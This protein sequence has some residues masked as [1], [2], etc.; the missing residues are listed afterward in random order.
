MQ[1]YH[2]HCTGIKRLFIF[3]QFSIRA[4]TLL[5]LLPLD[6]FIASQFFQCIHWSFLIAADF[7]ALLAVGWPAYSVCIF[8]GALILIRIRYAKHSYFITI[9]HHQNGVQH[10]SAEQRL[11]QLFIQATPS[12]AITVASC[13][14]LKGVQ[15]NNKSKIISVGR[16]WAQKS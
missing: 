5:M 7:M 9:Q 16:R 13:E 2:H 10:T 15:A 8:V 4:I 11:K 14:L 3:T 6:C 12:V 1:I